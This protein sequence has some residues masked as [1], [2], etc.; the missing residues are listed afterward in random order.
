MKEIGRNTMEFWSIVKKKA[1]KDRTLI[2]PENLYDVYFDDLSRDPVGV[3]E[4]IYKHFGYDMKDTTVRKLK[5]YSEDNAKGKK[6]GRHIHAFS[7][8][9]DEGD[10]DKFFSEYR[11]RFFLNKK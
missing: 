8:F 6:H 11:Q 5:K 2:K 4:N 10:E 3:V 1:M 7:D 9:F